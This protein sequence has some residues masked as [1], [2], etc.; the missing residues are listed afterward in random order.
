V[1]KGKDADIVYLDFNRAFDTVSQ[2]I[3][4]GK[5]KAHGMD[6]YIPLGHELAT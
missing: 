3:L 5:L 2:S 4:L 1:G 6:R